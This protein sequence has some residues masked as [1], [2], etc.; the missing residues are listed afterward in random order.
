MK[1]EYS[2]KVETAISSLT[3]T[4]VHDFTAATLHNIYLINLSLASTLMCTDCAV[5]FNTSQYSIREQSLHVF[6]CAT[7][8]KT[9]KVTYNIDQCTV[10]RST[11]I[12]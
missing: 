2:I 5:A 8:V 9:M 4:N 12:G 1:C 3:H 6:N 10:L 7:Q 11:P